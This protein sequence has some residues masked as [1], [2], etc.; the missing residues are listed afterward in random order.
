LYLVTSRPLLN[1]IERVQ[2]RA[3]DFDVQFT[4]P[5]NNNLDIGGIANITKLTPDTVRAIIRQTFLNPNRT[6]QDQTAIVAAFQ[7]VADQFQAYSSTVVDPTYGW[8]DG[9]CPGIVGIEH[10]AESGA[11]VDPSA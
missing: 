3:G 7:T 2:G 8:Q 9:E 11:T 10:L 6:A 4:D 1:A 5:K